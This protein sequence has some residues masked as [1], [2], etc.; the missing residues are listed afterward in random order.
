VDYTAKKRMEGMMTEKLVRLLAHPF[1]VVSMAAVFVL[2]SVW[3]T[4]G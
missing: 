4:A 2:A 3:N 1:T